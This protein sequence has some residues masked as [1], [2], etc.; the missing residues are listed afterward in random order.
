MLDISSSSPGLR[1]LIIVPS[2][3]RTFGQRLRVAMRAKGLKN[4]QLAKAVGVHKGTVSYWLGDSFPP[5]DEN[6]AAIAAALS[7]EPSWLKYGDN[8]M[9]VREPEPTRYG[10]LTFDSTTA[11]QRGRVWLEQFLLEIAEEGATQE[12]I[13]SSRR[14]LMNPANYEHGFG[15]AAGHPDE[16]D[17]DQKLRHMQALAVGIRAALK[18]R[19][20]KGRK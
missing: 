19:R 13:D 10:Q 1:T 7:V 16:M 18:E 20:K 15:A 8:G 11:T 12:F 6:L 4:E 9:V 5:S 17:D 2:D 3:S 14:L